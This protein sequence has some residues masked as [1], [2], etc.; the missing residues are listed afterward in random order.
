MK[1][2]IAVIGRVGVHRSF[3]ER[4][5]KLLSQI[6]PKTPF[7][8]SVPIYIFDSEAGPFAALSRH[9]EQGY[10]VSALF[11]NDR[12]N[13]WALKNLGVEKIISW[14]APGS[15][16][17]AIEPGNLVVPHDVLEWV[18]R[19][20]SDPGTFFK[21]QGPG[22]TR[23]W[24]AFCPEMRE[25]LIV[26]LASLPL[27]VHSQGVYAATTGPRL[28]TA[29]EV[30]ALSRLGASLVGMTLCPELWLAR[31][32]EFCY[33]AVCY[34][35]NFAEGVRE[36]PFVPGVLFEGLATEEEFQRVAEMEQAF[37]DVV[38]SVLPAVA[39]TPRECPCPR[40]LERYRRRG[41]LR[42]GWWRYL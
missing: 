16:D 13:L 17:P 2:K 3:E 41:D 28:E 19:G 11:V 27:E 33:A 42:E 18:G 30:Q 5:L 34:S 29:A 8:P 12:A 21:D 7:G 9:G 36:R 6:V 23:A 20:A 1:P 35:V 32:L 14:S 40:L 24:P 26:A 38:L 25:A 39:E 4:G 22:V 10:D 37:P 31:E 15:L